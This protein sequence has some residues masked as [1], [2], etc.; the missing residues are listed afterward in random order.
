MIV[1]LNDSETKQT[2]EV[3]GNY[4]IKIIFHQYY[5]TKVIKKRKWDR[6]EKIQRSNQKVSQTIQFKWIRA[7][8]Q[9]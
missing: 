6:I 7:T 5:L 9:L 3:T 4:F 1:H 8:S 2:D